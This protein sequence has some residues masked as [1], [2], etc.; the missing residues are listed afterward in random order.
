MKRIYDFYFVYFLCPLFFFNVLPLFFFLRP[1]TV[2]VVGNETSDPDFSKACDSVR[3]LVL[4]S[5]T[6]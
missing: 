5:L 4:D 1:R 3:L 6:T 2:A